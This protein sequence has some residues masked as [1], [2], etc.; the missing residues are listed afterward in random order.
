M[1][2]GEDVRFRPVADISGMADDTPMI[3]KRILFLLLTFVGVLLFTRFI[4]F[5]FGHPGI[6]QTEADFLARMSRSA[7]RVYLVEFA[8]FIV[9]LA[10]VL[11]SKPKA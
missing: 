1:A 5:G 8:I 11:R 7:T 4:V 2:V 3:W 10:L 9:A 6:G